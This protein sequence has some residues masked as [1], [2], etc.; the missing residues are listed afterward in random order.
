MSAD[1]SR[2]YPAL[3]GRSVRLEPLSTSHVPGL[4]RAAQDIGDTG[5]L[6]I[7]PVS[8]PDT[9]IYVE[10]ALASMRA[11]QAYPFAIRSLADDT[12]VG[13]TRLATFERW[14][15]GRQPKPDRSGPDAVEIGWT[16]LS[17]RAQRTAI[18]TEAKWLLLSYAFETMRVERVML[19]TDA[20]NQ[21]SRAAIQ[22]IGATFEGILRRHGPAADGGVRDSAI[23]S[24]VA[25]EWPTLKA[26]LQAKLDRT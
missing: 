7:V 8:E 25:P 12:I 24:I 22:R 10:D 14:A 2:P 5:Q 17:Q 26:A 11:N 1:D 23:F 21:R 4:W 20:R 13:S 9:Q 15:W 6:T 18:N 19:K 16:W 3:Q